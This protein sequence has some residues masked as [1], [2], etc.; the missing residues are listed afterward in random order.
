MRN[1]LLW[2]AVTPSEQAFL[3]PLIPDLNDTPANFMIKLNNLKNAPLQQYNNIRTT[4]WLPALDE[5]S[6]LNFKNRVNLYR[7]GW[8]TEDAQPDTQTWWGDT[9][10]DFD[11]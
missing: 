8:I 10:A 7:W 6:L 1:Q 2:S 11:L 3:A 5:D 9:W 4:Y